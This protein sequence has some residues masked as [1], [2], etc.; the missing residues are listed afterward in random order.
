MSRFSGLPRRAGLILGLTGLL[1]GSATVSAQTQTDNGGGNATAPSAGPEPGAGPRA[2]NT[3]ATDT[4]PGP[5]LIDTYTVE[6]DVYQPQH[7]D[8]HPLL[9]DIGAYY[10]SPLHWDGKDWAYLGGA[11]AL[12][13]ASHHYDTQVRTHFI[14]QGAKPLGGKTH[15]LQD[16]LPGFAAFAGTWAYAH[17]LD[18]SNGYHEAWNM[19]EAG[20]LTIVDTYA[21]KFAAGR[22]RPDQT[23]D[24]NKWRKSGSSF[25]SLHA[26][27]AFAIGTILAESGNDDYRWV[28]RFL[29][30]GA[31]AGFTAFER[32]KHNAHW[33]SDDI[34]GA[35]IGVA[36]AHFVMVRSQERREAAGNYSLSLVPIEGGAMVSYNLTLK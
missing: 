29:G 18:N 22:E 21:L 23:S 33:L 24:P 17:W 20:G 6:P 1:L 8:P 4:A 15:D 5:H 10:T 13:A 26:G 16:A 9:H 27:A 3:S 35:E 32:L 30:Y 25:P 2:T 36:T 28:R 11:V 14:A 12:W 7:T 19:L 31:V 34:A